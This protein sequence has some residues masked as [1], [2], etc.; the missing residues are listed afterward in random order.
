MGDTPSN[1]TVAGELVS[2]T[3]LDNIETQAKMTLS[4]VRSC[5]HTLLQLGFIKL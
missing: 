1:L 5:Y 3:V 2:L 4:N